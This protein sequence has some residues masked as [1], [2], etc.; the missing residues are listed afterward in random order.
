MGKKKPIPAEEVPQG[1]AKPP[2][3]ASSVTALRIGIVITLIA[4]G[5]QLMPLVNAGTMDVSTAV[6]RAALVS[7]GCGIGAFYILRLIDDYRAQIERDRRVQETLQAIQEI[8]QD[9]PTAI[10]PPPSQQEH[11]PPE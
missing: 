7:I 3:A 1:P 2:R 4:L 6:L 9:R 10:E 11:Q 8:L 5:P